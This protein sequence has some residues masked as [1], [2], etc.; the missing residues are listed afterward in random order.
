MTMIILVV[1]FMI[2]CV[3]KWHYQTKLITKAMELG[4]IKKDEPEEE[5]EEN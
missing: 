3:L 1:C 5:K 4:Y 2:W